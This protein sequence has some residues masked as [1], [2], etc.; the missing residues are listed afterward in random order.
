MFY[1]VLALGRQGLCCNFGRCNDGFHFNARLRAQLHFL[2]KHLLFLS[3]LRKSGSRKVNLQ[4]E[5]GPE[6]YASET[7]CIR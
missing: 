2:A 1:K 7:A 4:S 5:F 6:G 3:S